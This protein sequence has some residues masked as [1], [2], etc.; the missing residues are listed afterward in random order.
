MS[1]RIQII[2]EKVENPHNIYLWY[3]CLEHNQVMGHYASN[4]IGL[5]NLLCL[6]M[7]LSS[8]PVKWME[9]NRVMDNFF[10]SPF[11]IR[12]EE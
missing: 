5:M 9:L 7:I 10:C 6:M 2:T 11:E 12:W 4:F 3:V 1:S 8:G